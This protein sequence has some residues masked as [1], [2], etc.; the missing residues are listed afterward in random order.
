LYVIEE[1]P[2]P[3]LAIDLGQKLVDI[4][5]L[6]IELQAF[7]IG[8]PDPVPKPKF[9]KKKGTADARRLSGFEVTAGRAMIRDSRF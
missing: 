5:R 8:N 4:A 7:P 1:A 6:H 9:R 3:I 2:R